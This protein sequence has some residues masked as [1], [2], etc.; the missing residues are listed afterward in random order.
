MLELN[1]QA[2]YGAPATKRLVESI[3]LCNY[4][5][6]WHLFAWCQLRSEYRDFRLDRIKGLKITN[7]TFKGK[8]HIPMADF[9][10]QM[11]VIGEKAN[12]VLVMKTE[13]IRLI[14]ES[15][16]WYGFTEAEKI[17]DQTSRVRF[18][19]NELRGFA[20]WI[21]ASGSYAHVEEPVE[22]KEIVDQI[23]SGI[24]ENYKKQ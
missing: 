20:N 3:G 10:G 5:R 9:I 21:V 14:D 4:S 7:E 16:Y 11:G 13:R 12:I 2:G 6:R 19:N 1:Y 17:D 18:A 22:L 8:Q 23:I 24:I 15:K